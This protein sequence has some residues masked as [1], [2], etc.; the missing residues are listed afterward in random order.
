[1]ADAN[2]PRLVGET[3]EIPGVY[4]SGGCIVVKR[5]LMN[6]NI[7]EREGVGLA[8]GATQFPTLFHT[9]PT[10][11]GLIPAFSRYNS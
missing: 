2:D 4:R 11:M 3:V 1:M 7:Q 6:C 5:I 10:P 8:T 9:A